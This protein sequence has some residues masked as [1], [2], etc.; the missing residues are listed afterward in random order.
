[1]IPLFADEEGIGGGGDGD[2]AEVGGF[3]ALDTV[4]VGFF[5]GGGFFQEVELLDFLDLARIG[6]IVRINGDLFLGLLLVVRPAPPVPARCVRDNV[7]GIFDLARNTFT[8][9]TFDIQAL[10][11]HRSLAVADIDGH[12]LR[13][14]AALKLEF[15]IDAQHIQRIANKRINEIALHKHLDGITKD[16][17]IGEFLG[18]LRILN[19]K[20]RQTFVSIEIEKKVAVHAIQIGFFDCPCPPR[21]RALFACVIVTVLRR[22][23]IGSAF[24][25]ARSCAVKVVARTP[26]LFG[27]KFFLS[28]KD[29]IG[30]LCPPIGI[31]TGAEP[32]AQQ[33]SQHHPSPLSHSFK[34][35]FLSP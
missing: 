25:S 12:E 4:I 17:E 13:N 35:C 26:K 10:E 29:F 20:D 7:D 15:A 31:A 21:W 3:V 16:G 27:R 14:V 23:G 32:E 22:R 2:I 18:V 33:T 34:H 1:M 5:V 30:D 28:F 8:K 11:N 19:I 9:L 6:D 24:C